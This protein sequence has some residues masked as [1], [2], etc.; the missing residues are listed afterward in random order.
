M[1][2]IPWLDHDDPFPEP[3]HFVQNNARLPDGLIAVSETMTLSRLQE[4]YRQGIF[5]WYSEGEAVMWWCT[6]PRMVLRPK[7]LIVRRSLR[8]K[9]KQVCTDPAWEIRV[10][11]SFQ[12]VMLACASSKRAGQAG[13][14]I[15]S[16]IIAT[17]TAMHQI[18]QAHSVE[19]WYNNQLVGGLYCINLGKM[20]YGESMFTRMTDA[21]KLA[22][23]ALCAW[24]ESV[25]I[26]MIDCQQQTQHL[27]SLGA[28]P[29]RKE[30]FLDWI[31]SQIDLPAPLWNW[32]KSVLC[33]Y[34]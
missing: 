7:E 32:N 33:A 1:T 6:S 25:G 30:E 21:S 28:L 11:S 34:N 24:S 2:A 29:I 18:G 9:I 8:K 31:A 5:P 10:D 27:A 22:L 12:E 19:T 23:C 26:A 15:T 16:D 3:R 4:A 20:I 13:T 14:W 17:Y